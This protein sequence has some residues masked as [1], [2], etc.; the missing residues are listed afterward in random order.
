[1]ASDMSPTTVTQIRMIAPLYG[2]GGAGQEPSRYDSFVIHADLAC[3][4]TRLRATRFWYA[5]EEKDRV[6]PHDAAMA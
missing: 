2:L 1:M 3:L 4:S 6:D 5:H